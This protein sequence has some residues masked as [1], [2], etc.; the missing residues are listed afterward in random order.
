MAGLGMSDSQDMGHLLV[1]RDK[2]GRLRQEIAEMQTSNEQFR[3]DGLNGADAQGCTVIH[4]DIPLGNRTPRTATATDTSSDLQLLE[5]LQ[6]AQ[7][8]RQH[9]SGDGKRDGV[10]HKSSQLR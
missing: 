1:L 2:I 7:E 10:R 9:S 5:V 6:S 3:R 8:E 4:E